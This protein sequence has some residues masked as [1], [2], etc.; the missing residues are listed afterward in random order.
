M[1]THV[2]IIN[3]QC[4]PSSAN[5]DTVFE[6][7]GIN[8]GKSPSLMSS[9]EDREDLD[10]HDDEAFVTHSD[11]SSS[12]SSYKS[13][14]LR[15]V[16]SNSSEALVSSSPS[17]VLSTSSDPI[18][19]PRERSD[20]SI[21][22]TNESEPERPSA[23]SSNTLTLNEERTTVSSDEDDILSPKGVSVGAGGRGNITK[24]PERSK[25][26]VSKATHKHSRSNA[27]SSDAQSF[28][29][30]AITG[31]RSGSQSNVLQSS[32]GNGIS[33]VFSSSKEH[34]SDEKQL[35]FFS[36]AL[37]GIRPSPQQQRTP[38]DE[39]KLKA[40]RL[41][42]KLK[43]MDQR[44]KKF[45]S[46]LKELENSL[47]KGDI[48]TKAS[49][50][51]VGIQS[52]HDP[53]TEGVAAG[54]SSRIHVGHSVP[55]SK[56]ESNENNFISGRADEGDNVDNGLE[57]DEHDYHDDGNNSM[58]RDQQDDQR[59]STPHATSD[60][61][62]NGMVVSDDLLTCSNDNGDDT[63]KVESTAGAQSSSYDANA[64]D[65][66]EEDKVEDSMEMENN[67]NE[68]DD[69][70]DEK[71]ELISPLPSPRPILLAKQYSY[72][73][74]RRKSVKLSSDDKKSER[75]SVGRQFSEEVRSLF[76]QR[77]DLLNDKEFSQIFQMSKTEFK[78]LPKWRQQELKKRYNLF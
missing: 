14:K 42:N 24:F 78:D 66:I 60:L 32:S 61:D 15:L 47:S 76:H 22:Y 7:D 31:I 40:L 30:R 23:S 18:F 64:D 70:I 63:F 56:T 29:S 49:R 62:R 54:I 35:D 50:K 38:D 45:D 65:D 39:K 77:E 9:I 55:G 19:T 46:R 57:K 44:S 16:A 58:G 51:P 67:N 13:L 71:D 41:E 5:S 74:L 75:L 69:D 59:N 11:V 36:R 1:C 34:E 20:S 43:Q 53:K 17:R 52:R 6:I 4:H 10:F 48:R 25:S 72:E 27:S 26:N 8:E 12:S 21:S 28:F 3:N 68:D 73:E 37:T 2:Q 33:G